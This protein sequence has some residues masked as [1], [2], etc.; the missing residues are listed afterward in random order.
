LN[1]KTTTNLVQIL[2]L[3]FVC[4]EALNLIILKE[5]KFCNWRGAPV[6]IFDSSI[7]RSLSKIKTKTSFSLWNSRSLTRIFWSLKRIFS[8]YMSPVNYILLYDPK[9]RKI[10]RN[11]KEENWF[12]SQ[13]TVTVTSAMVFVYYVLII[14]TRAWFIT[15]NIYGKDWYKEIIPSHGQLLISISSFDSRLKI[16]K[17]FSYFKSGGYHVLQFYT[18]VQPD[19]TRYL[20]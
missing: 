7:V 3:F 4:L 16:L 8:R 6:S 17:G 19:F 2:H 9:S 12:Y 20:Q 14:I 5:I 1:Q 18:P 10:S 15:I 13:T 11:T